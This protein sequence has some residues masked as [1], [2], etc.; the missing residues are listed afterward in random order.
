MSRIVATQKQFLFS[1]PGL[2]WPPKSFSATLQQVHQLWGYCSAKPVVAPISDIIDVKGPDTF[3][4][5]I[6]AGN[7]IA[8]VKSLDALKIFSVRGTDIRTGRSHR[9]SRGIRASPA[10]DAK[11]DQSSWVRPVLSKSDGPELTS[12]ETVI[13]GG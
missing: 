3:V 5:T 6:Y 1:H 13:S 9:R 4:R 12:A 11:N 10:C 8:T 2:L 7:A